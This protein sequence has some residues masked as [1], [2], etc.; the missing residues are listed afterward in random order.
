MSKNSGEA[1]PTLESD[2]EPIPDSAAPQIVEKS[3]FDRTVASRLAEVREAIRR[4]EG[5]FGDSPTEKLPTLS[6][7]A[8]RQIHKALAIAGSNIGA[9]QGMTA[10]FITSKIRVSQ[11]F[12]GEAQLSNIKVDA[13][14]TLD[15]KTGEVKK[16]ELL[17]DGQKV[18]RRPNQL[19][20][21]IGANEFAEELFRLNWI[22]DSE[23]L[24]SLGLE[25]EQMI[26]AHGRILSADGETVPVQRLVNGQIPAAKAHANPDKTHR[27]GFDRRRLATAERRI[28]ELRKGKKKSE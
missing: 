5:A 22:D 4:V 19:R 20:E 8:L 26:L 10:C 14:L 2:A 7:N 18:S 27:Q 11:E 12:L 9:L 3:P 17:K 25:I 13:L 28:K 21:T 6:Q 24:E 15:P 23:T 1:R 16:I